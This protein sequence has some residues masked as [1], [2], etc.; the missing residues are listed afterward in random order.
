ML[1]D[2]DLSRF[3]A[4][5]QKAKEGGLSHPS[6]FPQSALCLGEVTENLFYRSELSRLWRSLKIACAAGDAPEFADQI[7]CG[8]IQQLTEEDRCYVPLTYSEEWLRAIRWAIFR[9]ERSDVDCALF[10]GNDRQSRVGMACQ[11]LRKRGYRIHI[12]AYGPYLD[13]ETQKTIAD[14]IN[15]LIS[16]VGGINAAQQICAFV[17][18]TNAMHDGMWLFGN[19]IGSYGNVSESALPIGWLFSIALRH[20][21][22][23]ESLSEHEVAWQTAVK[24]AVDFAACMDCQIYNPFDGLHLHATDFYPTLEESLKWRELFSLPQVP[25]STLT[26]MRDAF[27]Q[28]EWPDGTN[29]LR[30]NV[31]RL[32]GELDVLLGGLFDDQLTAIPKHAACND[33]PLLWRHARGSLGAVNAS[34]LGPFEANRRNHD[35]TVF[36][37]TCDDNILALPRAM[38]AASACEV[39]FRLIWSIHR[40]KA[41]QIVSKTIEK[42]VALACQAHH[43]SVSERVR[44]FADGKWLEIDLATRYDQDLV[45]FES[46]A[47]SLTSASRSG[48]MMAFI[49]DY[50][51]SYLSLLRQ[52]VRNERNLKRGLTS[53]TETFEDPNSLR[54]VKV[55]VS[56]LC[57]GPASDKVLADGLFRSIAFARLE[58]INQ[59]AKN[60]RIVD[61]F[62]Q[63]IENIMSDLQHIAP[64]KYDQIDLFKYMLDVFWLD[65]GQLLYVLH[66]GF[67]V[68]QA[69]TA[70]KNLTFAT[71]DFWTEVALADCQQ[72]TVRKWHPPSGCDS[73][74]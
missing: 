13:T 37:E 24:L 66:R 70:L 25:P 45:L 26:T 20:I 30:Q 40:N 65:L 58:A 62:N 47:K 72:L 39:I 56:P 57:Y 43:D 11:R 73:E 2:S 41:D 21:H 68:T 27:S 53:L 4:L 54:I 49:D 71:R 22:R 28:V 74:S 67:T 48:D 42:C 7:L 23:K 63:T 16:Q 18:R 55:L 69:V 8:I 60:V 52:H 59:S 64:R 51:K 61:E 36:F 17:K 19:R 34:Y 50:T 12:G 44:Y 10:S 1:Q 6:E 3:I 31:D 33:F 35:R 14:S 9:A 29:D 5:L 46:K 32:F 15:S 38:T